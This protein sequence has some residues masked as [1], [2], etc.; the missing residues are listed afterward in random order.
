MSSALPII[1]KEKD[2][3]IGNEITDVAQGRGMLIRTG[4]GTDADPYKIEINPG[5]TNGDIWRWNGTN[6]IATSFTIPT[7]KDSI[8]GNEVLGVSQGAGCALE[9]M[10]KSRLLVGGLPYAKPRDAI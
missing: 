10:C 7:E 1:P 3:I 4:T 6:W 9:A 5:A 8:I 2:S